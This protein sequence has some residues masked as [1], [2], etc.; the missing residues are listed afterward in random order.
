MALSSTDKN[1]VETI[2]RKEIKNF[3]D[4]NTVKQFESKLIDTVSKELRRGKL[5]GDTKEIVIR[6]FREFYG[7]MW[8]NRSLW[9]PRLKN[10]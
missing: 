6:V 8:N 4:S 10:A 7:F 5:E 3:L 2:V 1:E 9:E